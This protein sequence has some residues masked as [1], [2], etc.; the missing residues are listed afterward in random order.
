MKTIFFVLLMFT[1]TQFFSQTIPFV[2]LPSGH[3]IIKAKVEGVEGN[4]IFDTGA[5]INIFFNDF[6][7]R[8]ENKPL[9][10]NFMTGFR[11]TGE[12]L[13]ISLFKSKEILFANETF[14]NI[15]FSTIDMKIPG[16]DGLISLKMFE[17]SNITVDYEK[18]EISINTASPESYSKAIDI[19][20][21]TQADNTLDISTSMTLDNKHE[22]KVLLDSGA[23][24]RSFWLSDKLIKILGVNTSTLEVT[25][26]QSEINSEVKNKISKGKLGVIGNEFV[27]IYKP[28]VTFVENLIYE[29][30]TGIDWI[31]RKFII[32]IK[33]R[34][35]YLL[36]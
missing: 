1:S 28:N 5:G 8:F 12:R 18:Q 34:K 4:F 20:V 13:D 26:N 21:S 3:L 33:N 11:A 25:M 32:S 17:S 31:G 14:R 9:S 6:V 10:S 16:V 15:P 29:G 24:S 27:K 19:F 22:I 7:S 35:I 23:G 36:D 2:L 30:K